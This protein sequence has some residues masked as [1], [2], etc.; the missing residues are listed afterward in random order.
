MGLGMQ[1]FDAAGNLAIDVTTRLSRVIGSTT[2]AAGS[3]GSIAVPNTTQ[4]AIWFAI[5]GNGGNRYSPVM[6]VSGGV[7]S[8]SP[9]TGF[10]GGA[11]DVTMLY[12]LY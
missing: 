2:I 6:S 9:R 8:W 12:G 10:P 5:Y 7:I 1:V 3:T 11:V 4:G